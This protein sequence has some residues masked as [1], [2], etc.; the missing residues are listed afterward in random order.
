[1]LVGFNVFN[2]TRIHFYSINISS[3]QHRYMLPP[4]FPDRSKLLRP[5]NAIGY[6]NQ[7]HKSKTFVF[8][9]SEGKKSHQKGGKKETKK[10]GRV[11]YKSYSSICL[12]LFNSEEDDVSFFVLYFLIHKPFP[13]HLL[14]LMHLLR[15]YLL[16]SLLNLNDLDLVPNRAQI[17]FPLFF[18]N[19]RF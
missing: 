12:E 18:R 8:P 14:L 1:M 13:S 2:I 16:L 17:D 15:L 5:S 9:Q 6:C 7:H 19:P 11:S 3:I 4:Q 10:T